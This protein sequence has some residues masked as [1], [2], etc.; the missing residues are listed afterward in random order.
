M[1]AALQ[2]SLCK[3]AR[4]AQAAVSNFLIEAAFVKP[5]V[6]DVQAAVSN[7]TITFPVVPH[8]GT[9]VVGLLP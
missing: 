9:Y 2:D 8:A 4:G 7:Y 3:A 5:H 1:W 6:F